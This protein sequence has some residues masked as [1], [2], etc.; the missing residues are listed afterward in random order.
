MP[1]PLRFFIDLRI[2]RRIPVVPAF[3]TKAA[4]F[5]ESGT[6]KTDKLCRKNKTPDH[7]FSVV[8][9]QFLPYL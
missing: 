6:K 2:G 7:A 4:R 1:V 3:L 9:V 5:M 8:P